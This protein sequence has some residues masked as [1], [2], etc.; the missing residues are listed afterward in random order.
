MARCS[1][2]GRNAVYF[3]CGRWLC[4]FCAYEI[5]GK[6]PPAIVFVDTETTG[7]DPCKDAI[8]Q[9]SAIRYQ[10]EEKL[11][12]WNTYVNPHRKIPADATKVNGITNAMV[13]SSPPIKELR[14]RFVEITKNSILV[15]Y[16]HP[17]DLRF[18]NMAFRNLLTGVLYIDMLPLV[19]GRF[20]TPD[21]KLETVA[22][23]LGF[24]PERGFHDSLADCEA[25]AAV[26]FHLLHAGL[27][28]SVFEY[29]ETAKDIE[30]KY[31]VKST[32]PSQIVP[33]EPPTD[34]N[35]PFYGKKIVF[36]GELSIERD[37]AMQLAADAGAEIKGS[38][39]GKTDFLVVGQQDITLVG[40]S[41]I[42][43]KERK[44]RE[45]NDSGKGHI[46]ILSEA[47]FMELV[48]QKTEVGVL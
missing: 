17:F 8:I 34:E 23:H 11:D 46:R 38:V 28:M 25:T 15:V 9:I 4:P 20:E 30:N 2:C 33:Q 21:N 3:I 45:L 14:S 42:S 24:H 13:R 16:N 1:S 43:G 6:D 35:H 10:G 32:P 31:G 39:S 27:Q 22:T 12:V 29:R 40:S 41:G 26:Y 44:A 7:L 19:K 18:L 5:L 48:Q 36:T 37:A 47:E